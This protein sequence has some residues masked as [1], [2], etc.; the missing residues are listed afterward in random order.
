MSVA[1]A[2]RDPANQALPANLA[3]ASARARITPAA[4]AGIVRLAA[5]WH[6]TSTEICTLIGDVSERTWFRMK[7]GEWEGVLSQD[8]LTRISALIGIFKGLRLLF[9]EG[10]AD[11]WVRLPNK[12]PL[13]GG[14]RPLD[15][16][17]EGG[18]PKLLQ[19]RQHIDA[20]RG[21]L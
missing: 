13:Y 8:S 19:V 7:K 17:I 6:L 14:R 15:V 3:D 2:V 10:L 21:G 4:V 11:E 18:I 1:Y 16:M 12:G 5:I 20:L 9:S